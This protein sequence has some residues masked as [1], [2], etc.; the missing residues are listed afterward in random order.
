MG[1]IRDFPVNPIFFSTVA[2]HFLSYTNHAPN[3]MEIIPIKKVFPT[4]TQFERPQN[5]TI[6][7]AG[8]IV[9][10]ETY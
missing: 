9:R 1:M 5:Q 6:D 10:E 3:D 2:E 7:P 8:L 4:E